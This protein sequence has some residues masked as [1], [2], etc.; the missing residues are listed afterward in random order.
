MDGFAQ[1]KESTAEPAAAAE[2]DACAGESTPA[3][4]HMQP[5]RCQAYLLSQ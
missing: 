2:G 3:R 1:V 5:G 4:M